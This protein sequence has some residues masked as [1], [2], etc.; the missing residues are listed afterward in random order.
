MINPTMTMGSTVVLVMTATV[1]YTAANPHGTD[2]N[3][4]RSDSAFM[5]Q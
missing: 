5:E 3:H 4:S 1:R 2:E